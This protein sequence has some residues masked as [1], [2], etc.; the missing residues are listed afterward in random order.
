MLWQ[1]GLDCK[2]AGRWHRAS[3]C[4]R[5]LTKTNAARWE[6]RKTLNLICRVNPH[7]Y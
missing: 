3:I 2:A 1:R 7:L 5:S 4:W 6:L